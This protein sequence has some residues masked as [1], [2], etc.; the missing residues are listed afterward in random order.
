ME[1]ENRR[2]ERIATAV[3]G[4]TFGIVFF[5]RN[6]LNFLMPFILRDIALTNTQ[7]GLAASGLALTWALSGMMIGRLSDRI[8]RRKPLLIGAVLAFSASSFVTGITWS[9]A[10][11][12]GARLLMGLAEG[13]VLPISQTLMAAASSPERRGRN[14]GLMQNVLSNLMG[15]L[16][17]P[18]VVV[19]LA[20]SYGWRYAF[21]LTALP[22]FVAAAL[23]WRY[24]EEPEPRARQAADRSDQQAS[25]RDVL[26]HRNIRLCLFISP[27][28]VGWMISGWVF[29]PIYFTSVAGF[30]PTQM[31]ALLSVLGLTGAIAGYLVP[32]LSDRFGRRLVVAAGCLLGIL[33]PLAAMW[34]VHSG[35]VAIAVLVATGWMAG[36]TISIVMATIPAE[37]SD[38]GQVTTAMA[39][40]MGSGELFGGTLAPTIVGWTMDRWGPTAPLMG[41]VIMIASAS[42]LALFLRNTTSRRIALDSHHAA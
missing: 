39:L 40:V 4:L 22:G 21:F 10:T 29:L 33:T 16:V 26:R 41:Q 19:A 30:T 31:S 5:D 37:S 9:F 14:M 8:G 28:I 15:S 35:A 6:A 27:L 23:I 34:G 12:L 7:I 32:A 2:Y 17:A 20:T 38:A 18:L 11:L 13:P 24:I 42:V 25:V 1:A 3:L 36:G